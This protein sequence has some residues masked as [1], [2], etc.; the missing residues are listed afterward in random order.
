MQDFAKFVSLVRIPGSASLKQGVKGGKTPKNAIKGGN[1]SFV[2][3]DRGEVILNLEQNG[4]YYSPDIYFNIKYV[5]DGKKITEKLCR[6][7]EKGFEN[8]DFVMEDG[9]ITNIDEA[10][11]CALGL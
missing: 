5:T 6:K 11:E 4:Q 3:Y 8:F 1:G 10:I 2:V 7:L 9:R